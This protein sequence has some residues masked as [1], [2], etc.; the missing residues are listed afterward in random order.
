MVNTE[1]TVRRSFAGRQRSLSE[2][3]LVSLWLPHSAASAAAPFSAPVFTVSDNEGHDDSDTA[4]QS[5]YDEWQLIHR[6][7]SSQSSL[8]RIPRLPRRPSS[9]L[10]SAMTLP[11]GSVIM[12]RDRLRSL[13]QRA[14]SHQK[15]GSAI[16]I[17]RQGL[18]KDVLDLSSDSLSV[19]EER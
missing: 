10:S 15:G 12:L 7:V 13:G 11:T 9:P 2:L 3:T 5:D 19:D 8:Q 1:N 14:L 18:D 17:I 6:R 16:D 4:A